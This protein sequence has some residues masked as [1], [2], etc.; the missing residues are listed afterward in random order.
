M[1][2]CKIFDNNFS[3]HKCKCFL[4]VI[5]LEILKLYF[6]LLRKFQSGCFLSAFQKQQ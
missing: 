6:K 3:K 5:V 2:L 4:S 1:H